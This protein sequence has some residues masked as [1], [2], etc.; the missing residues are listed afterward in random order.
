MLLNDDNELEEVV[1]SMRLSRGKVKA[2]DVP[3][4]QV[5]RASRQ[6]RSRSPAEIVQRDEEAETRE[7]QCQE[8]IDAAERQMHEED[9]A[10]HQDNVVQEIS[11]S[12]EK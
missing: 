6:L 7:L 5:I 2:P 9:F 4:R 10:S 8:Q 3:A 11:S 12:P 1:L